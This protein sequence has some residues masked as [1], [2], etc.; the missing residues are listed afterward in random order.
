MK[1]SDRTKVIGSLLRRYSLHNMQQK[2]NQELNEKTS[3][4]NSLINVLASESQLN[5]TQTIDTFG[6]TLLHC[7]AYN[8][9]VQ[10]VEILIKSGSKVAARD[11]NGNTPI[12]VLI[13]S[14]QSADCAVNFDA[15]VKIID[16]L[17]NEARVSHAV[18]ARDVFTDF[19]QLAPKSRL[20]Q[21]H[22]LLRKDCVTLRH[23]FGAKHDHRIANSATHQQ[24]R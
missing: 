8:H 24:F 18:V 23:A 7:A 6:W 10:L 14:L 11:S 15:V 12:H 13:Q 4:L 17:L 16:L 19:L 20:N 9:N 1:Q 22:Q 5:L 3:T 21:R 2:F